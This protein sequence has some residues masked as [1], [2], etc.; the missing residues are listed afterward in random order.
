M[1]AKKLSPKKNRG[2][3]M[4]KIDWDV[5]DGLCKIGCT[6]RELAAFFSCAEDTIQRAVKREKGIGFSEY[7]REKFA[8]FLISLR[9]TQ[10][11]LATKGHAGMAIWLGK[12]Y[13]GQVE[14]M[15]TTNKTDVS[16]QIDH[17]EQARKM[18]AVLLLDA[19]SRS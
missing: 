2:K 4:V 6:L 11:D 13:L 1:E 12:Q 17:D 3:P 9:R 18:Q 5:F 7:Y 15:E 14:K 8:H 19:Q 10:F 16:L